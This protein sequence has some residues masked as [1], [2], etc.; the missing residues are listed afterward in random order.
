MV[1]SQLRQHSGWPQAAAA[2]VKGVHAGR[3]AVSSLLLLRA[4]AAPPRAVAGFCRLVGDARATACVCAAPRGGCRTPA[5]ARGRRRRPWLSVLSPGCARAF[6]S[7][8]LSHVRCRP[9]LLPSPLLHLAVRT[10]C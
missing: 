10:G 7:A 2:G 6:C 1:R 9:P 4:A 8:G 5:A 3:G